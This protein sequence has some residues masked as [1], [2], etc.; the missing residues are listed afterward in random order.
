MSGERYSGIVKWFDVR[1]GYG[2]I[3]REDENKD[4]FVHFSGIKTDTEFKLLHENE[5]VTFEIEQGKKGPCAVNVM[6]QETGLNKLCPMSEMTNAGTPGVVDG[7][8]K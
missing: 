5:R 6:L 2:F 1:K 4:Y 7:T 8:E 3:T